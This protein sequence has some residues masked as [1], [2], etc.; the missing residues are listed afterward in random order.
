MEQSAVLGQEPSV[1]RQLAT[2]EGY[3]VG[4]C[5]GIVSPAT[6]CTDNMRREHNVGDRARG[7]CIFGGRLEY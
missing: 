3:S 4:N 6:C 1:P 7:S 2:S 5:P